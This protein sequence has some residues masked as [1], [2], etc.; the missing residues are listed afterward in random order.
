MCYILGLCTGVTHVLA[1]WSLLPLR[2][3]ARPDSV[4]S[5]TYK[6]LHNNSSLR[7]SNLLLSVKWLYLLRYLFRYLVHCPGLFLSVSTFIGRY[8]S[9]DITIFLSLEKL[10]LNG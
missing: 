2:R 10:A 5:L 4:H 6:K 1:T 8:L 7:A 3:N 9:L